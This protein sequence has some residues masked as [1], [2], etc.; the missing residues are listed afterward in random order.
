MIHKELIVTEK[1]IKGAQAL[2]SI[3]GKQHLV[4]V[5]AK[6]ECEKVEAEVGA[7]MTFDKV[8][9]LLNG[10]KTEFG[11]PYLKKSVKA[12]VVEHYRDRKVIIFKKLRRHGYQRKMGHRQP[13]SVLEILEIA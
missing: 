12:Q 1:S 9:C 5:G 13:V 2:V 6:I 11:A 8:L 10:D 3:Q 7:Q 4:H